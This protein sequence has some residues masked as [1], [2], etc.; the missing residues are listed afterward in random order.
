MALADI[1][2]SGP[3]KT[4][5]AAQETQPGASVP[6][7]AE[8]II[9]VDV[10]LTQDHQRSAEVTDSPVETGADVSD[11]RRVKPEVFKMR[12]IVSDIDPE[13]GILGGIAGAATSLVSDSSRSRDAYLTLVDLFD[14]DQVFTIVTS[15]Q[16]YPD[17]V[18]TD[19]SVHIDPQTG[20][21]I[22]FE[23]TVRTI[24]FASSEFV[25]APTVKS[26]AHTAPKAKK[27]AVKAPI[28]V[29]KAGSLLLN[30]GSKASSFLGLTGFFGL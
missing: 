1:I 14:S 23:A 19:L 2:S 22:D 27:P 28:P 6:I 4:A 29:E 5:I 24:R 21:A 8:T 11:H 16:V 9:T 17:M 30:L 10:T 12:G 7:R 15:L 25:D 3:L 26:V 20:K 18:F 13:A